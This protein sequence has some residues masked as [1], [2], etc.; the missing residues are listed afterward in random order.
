MIYCT[1]IGSTFFEPILLAA[2]LAHYCCQQYWFKN[3]EPMLANIVAN[4]IGSKMFAPMLANIGA[5]NIGSRILYR[6][7]CN[8]GQIGQRAANMSILHQHVP[9]IVCYLGTVM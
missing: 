7:W 2:M 3:V 5:N 8:I 6:Y 1:N 4:N 9:N